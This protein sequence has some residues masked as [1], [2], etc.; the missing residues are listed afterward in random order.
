MHC[1]LCCNDNNDKLFALYNNH[2]RSSY[3][4]YDIHKDKWRTLSISNKPIYMNPFWYSDNMLYGLSK[5]SKPLSKQT[6]QMNT[7]DLRDS[8][9]EWISKNVCF[10]GLDVDTRISFWK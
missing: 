8:A 1:K 2:R 5:N 3:T 7:L 9:R 10:D 6:Y 4:K